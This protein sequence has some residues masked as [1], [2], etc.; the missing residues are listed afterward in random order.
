MFRKVLLT[1]GLLLAAQVVAFA[2]GTMNGTISDGESGEQR[3]SA[4]IA[5][6]QAGNVTGGAR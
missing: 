1:I 3:R 6:E 4:R 2:Q 5:A